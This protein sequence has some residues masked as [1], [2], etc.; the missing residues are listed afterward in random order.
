MIPA[1][2][3]AQSLFASK[4]RLDV[5]RPIRAGRLLHGE[6]RVLVDLRQSRVLGLT[7]A[8]RRLG[9]DRTDRRTD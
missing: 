1:L 7:K 3:T 2:Q 5:R 9:T 6:V 8:G 4:P